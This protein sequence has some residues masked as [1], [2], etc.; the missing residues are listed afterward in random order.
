V[1][2][3]HLL[4]AC[5]STSLDS[6]AQAPDIDRGEQSIQF[7]SIQ[8]GIQTIP[9]AASQAFDYS[10]LACGQL[11]LQ[12]Q[13]PHTLLLPL[14]GLQQIKFEHLQLPLQLRV[15]AFLKIGPNTVDLGGLRCHLRSAD[16]G[17]FGA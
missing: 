7:N 11:I 13:V 3:L 1:P 12:V 9:S 5:A 17:E 14:S 16:V 2:V 10:A 15:N 8:A 6:S 4:F